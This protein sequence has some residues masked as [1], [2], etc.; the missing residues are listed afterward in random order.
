MNNSLK[1]VM[2]VIVVIFIILYVS[3][4]ALDPSAYE[5]EDWQGLS[6]AQVEQLNTYKVRFER[7][8]FH[9][10]KALESISQLESILSGDSIIEDYED[11]EAHLKILHHRTDIHLLEI[12]KSLEKYEEFPNLSQ[13]DI[14]DDAIA[15]LKVIDQE[16]LGDSLNHEDIQSAFLYTL[17]ALA[18][19]ELRISKV[20]YRTRHDNLFNLAMKQAQLH[21][22]SA[23][24][25]DFTSQIHGERFHSIDAIAFEELDSL[26][27]S[28]GV[29]LAV[30]DEQILHISNELDSLLLLLDIDYPIAMQ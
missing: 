29:S 7:N 3:H 17:N 28:D 14:L 11:A 20:A 5:K 10:E 18:K 26:M 22:K 23:L 15:R 6:E 2:M 16:V 13:V 30:V 9:L 24:L 1:I 21:I 19:A 27:K 25:M 4:R 8:A 12:I